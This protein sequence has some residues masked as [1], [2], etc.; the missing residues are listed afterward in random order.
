MKHAIPSTQTK[1]DSL[2]PL[3]TYGYNVGAKPFEFA[4]LLGDLLLL[5]SIDAMSS[6][7]NGVVLDDAARHTFH[8]C[9]FNYTILPV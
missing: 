6:K 2:A 5:K 4:H 9:I 1:S 7:V 3:I 8:V